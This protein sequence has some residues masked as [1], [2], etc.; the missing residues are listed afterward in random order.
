[1]GVFCARG[2]SGVKAEAADGIDAGCV[3]AC[4]TINQNGEAVQISDGNLLVP[5]RT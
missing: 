1:L 5:R 3:A 2:W 4:S